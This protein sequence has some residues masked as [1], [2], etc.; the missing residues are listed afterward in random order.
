MRKAAVDAYGSAL[1]IVF[2]FQA[3]ANFIAFLCCLPIQENPLPC[4]FSF[5]FSTSL[6]KAKLNHFDSGSQEEQEAQYRRM[7]E[8]EEHGR[9]YSNND[10]S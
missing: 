2:I 6:K 8:R 1:Q 9:Q 3:T 5:S 7:R 10:A 4:V